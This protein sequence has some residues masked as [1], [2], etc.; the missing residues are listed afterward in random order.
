MLG[1]PDAPHSHPPAASD[2]QRQDGGQG[3]EGDLQC[4]FVH[5]V[6]EDELLQVE[7]GPL[8]VRFLP[9]LHTCLPHL[10][11]CE[12]SLALRAHQVRH[13]KLHHKGLPGAQGEPS[14]PHGTAT[15]GRGL[16]GHGPAEGSQRGQGEAASR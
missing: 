8:V 16:T 4:V 7:K 11:A 13:R 1:S 2:T 10:V 9:R 15:A 14:G 3:G 5:L 12:G 6:L